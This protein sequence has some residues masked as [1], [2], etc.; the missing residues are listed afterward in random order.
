MFGLVGNFDVTRNL[1]VGV[2]IDNLF[3]RQPERYGA[4]QV[5]NIAGVNGG[6]TRTYNGAGS[7]VA[8][9]YDVLGRRYFMNVKLR[10]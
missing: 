7:T 6:G 10:F 9:F 1:A 3:D 4:G 5:I 2:G 8:S